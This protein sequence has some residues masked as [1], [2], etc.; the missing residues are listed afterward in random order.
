MSSIV[1]EHSRVIAAF[2]EP[3]LSLLRGNLAPANVAILRSGFPQ[4][5]KTQP[6][7]RLHQMVDAALSELRERGISHVPDGDGREVCMG[8]V[9]RRWLTRDVDGQSYTL[10]SYA[11]QALGLVQSLTRDRV[12]LSEHRIKNIVETANRLNAA[13]NPDRDARIARLRAQIAQQQAELERLEAGEPIAPVT[14]DFILEGLV[15]LQDLVS[16]LPIEFARVG[17]VVEALQDRLRE[18]FRAD[19]R[20]PGDIVADFLIR[21]DDLTTAT[22]EGRAFEGAFNLLDDDALTDQLRSDIT[23]LVEHPDISPVLTTAEKQTMIGIVRV[24][25]DGARDT[26]AKI[27]D[28][29]ETLNTYIR[30]RNISEDRELDRVLMQLEAGLSAWMQT[31]GP[32]ETV[33]VEMLPDGLDILHLKEKLYDPASDVP[34]DPLEDGAEEDRPEAMSLDE[35]RRYGG[36]HLDALRGALDEAAASDGEWTIGADVFPRLAADERRPVDALGLLH[37]IADRDDLVRTGT[38]EAYVTRRPDGTEQVLLLPQITPTRRL[39]DDQ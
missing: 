27:V 33:P 13:S 24:V 5:S 18:D 34:L 9:R 11:M 28:T 17:E 2:G 14:A 21:A 7:A 22:P 39:D 32:R 29:I 36:P 23:A 1:A 31:A 19:E 25:R 6:T 35:L 8:W 12:N 30:S 15:E 3:T 10:T 38:H 37:L 16:G 26:M 4:D 20:P